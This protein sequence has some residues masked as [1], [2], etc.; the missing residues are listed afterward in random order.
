MLFFR[1][2]Q[3]DSVGLVEIRESLA[4]ISNA[5]VKKINKKLKWG[6][7]LVVNCLGRKEKKESGLSFSFLL[8]QIH[9]HTHREKSGEV[10]I[11]LPFVK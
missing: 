7:S 2:K 8:K 5:A 3:K 11:F 1:R 4:G 10:P 6:P 9:P